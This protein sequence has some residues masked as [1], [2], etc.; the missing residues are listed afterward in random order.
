MEEEIEQEKRTA[1][2]IVTGMVRMCMCGG[3]GCVCVYMCVCGGGRVCLCVCVDWLE[4][5]SV[6]N[7]CNREWNQLSTR[8]AHT[9]VESQ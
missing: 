5:K 8:T 6:N 2:N 1:E 3:G 9:I 4:E 7:D